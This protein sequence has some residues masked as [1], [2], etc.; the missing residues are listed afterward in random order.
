MSKNNKVMKEY[1]NIVKIYYRSLDNHKYD[2]LKDILYPEFTHYR[3]DR[4]IETRKSFIS[5]MKNQR[6]NKNTTHKIDEIY[7]KKKEI[8]IKGQLQKNQNKKLFEF[9]DVFTFTQKTKTKIKQ[10]KTYTKTQQ[11]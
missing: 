5:F 11:N 3:P 4:T 7:T 8:A 10:I 6:P 9:I 2:K 1:R